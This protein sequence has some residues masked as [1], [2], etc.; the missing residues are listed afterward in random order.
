MVALNEKQLLESL[1]ILHGFFVITLNYNSFFFFNA[2][3]F[4]FFV[5]LVY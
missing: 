5:V 3:C 2:S 1:W 4:F